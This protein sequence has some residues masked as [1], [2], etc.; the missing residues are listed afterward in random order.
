LT[1][2]QCPSFDICPSCFNSIIA[3]TEFRHLFVPAARRPP[4][5]EVLC[6]FGSSPWYRIAWL[7]TRKERRRDL[8]LFYGLA[9]IAA[10]YQPCLGKHE[11]VR[12]WHSVIDHKTGAPVRGFDV[13]YSCVK[14]V[15]ILLPTIRGVF[16]RTESSSSPRICD[17]RFDSKRFVQYFDALE[18]AADLA[19]YHDDPP[20]TRD[21]ASLARRLAMFEECQQDKDLLDRRWHMITQLPE[22]T[23]CEECFDEVVWPELEEGKAIPLM[24][25]KTLQRLP[26]ASCQLYS[27]KM[28]GIFR[29][30]VDS[31]DYKMLASKARERKSIESAYKAN[32]GELRRQKGGGI[33]EREVGRLEEEWRKWE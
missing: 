3:P 28:R 8:N 16:V 11:A 27:A 13:C 25:N 19:S 12:Q 14:S 6:D 24:F 9:N 2:P 22:F 33:V 10:N 4:D 21:L 7:L 29:L 1:L 17:L 18:T 30:A 15:E 32:L 20:D 26:K 23:V 31:G 5:V